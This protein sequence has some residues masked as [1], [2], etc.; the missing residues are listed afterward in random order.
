MVSIKNQLGEL[1]HK[2]MDRRDFLKYAGGVI[3]AVIGV[4]G[5]VRLLLGARDSTSIGATDAKS[6]ESGGYGS[7]A[8]GG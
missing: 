7:S 5:L 4:T 6:K 2:E 1:L 8:Y 3:L